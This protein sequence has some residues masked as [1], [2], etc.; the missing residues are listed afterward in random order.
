MKPV[1]A[2]LRNAG[3]ISSG[4]IDDSLL[5]GKTKQ[6]CLDNI[7]DTVELMI[8]LGF[9]INLEKSVMIPTKL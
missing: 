3:N 7:K 1:Y 8:Q 4:F 6:L 9:M 5:A 2:T